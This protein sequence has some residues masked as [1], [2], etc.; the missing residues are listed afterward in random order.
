MVNKIK[1]TQK[2]LRTSK[3]EKIVDN[4]E[5]TQNVVKNIENT[6]KNG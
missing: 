2:W 6:K 4:F 5:H 3:T 1:N